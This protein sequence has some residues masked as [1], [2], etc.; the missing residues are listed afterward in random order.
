MTAYTA[1]L[2]WLC[3]TAL[4]G[5]LLVLGGCGSSAPDTTMPAD[6]PT[7]SDEEG[8]NP[9]N[10]VSTT[11]TV[12]YVEM[13]GG[14]WAII[15]PDSTRYDPS[16]S[17]PDSLQTEGL[18]IRFRGEEKSSQPSIRMWGTPIDLL[19]AMPIDDTKD[20]SE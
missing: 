3:M 10:L 7:P 19:E 13:E 6:P 1:R 17:L 18:E 16:G 4:L 20:N 15:T 9:E 8:P 14:F 5:A 11:G 2:G 12:T